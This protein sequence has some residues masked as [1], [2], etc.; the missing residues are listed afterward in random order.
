ME[1]TPAHTEKTKGEPLSADGRLETTANHAH[2]NPMNKNPLQGDIL[3]EHTNMKKSNR[4]TQRY[5]DR[6]KMCVENVIKEL[7]WYNTIGCRGLLILACILA[8]A[9]LHFFVAYEYTKKFTYMNRE[10]YGCFLFLPFCTDFL[11]I[12][13]LGGRF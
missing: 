10:A 6:K 2:E 1:L 4:Y 12:L 3:Q 11:H 8:I 9:V 5:T 13:Y 7:T